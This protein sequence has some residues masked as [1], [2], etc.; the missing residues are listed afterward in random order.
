MDSLIEAALQHPTGDAVAIAGSTPNHSLQHEEVTGVEIDA[1]K[2]AYEWGPELQEA[3]IF[4]EPQKHPERF[5]EAF[6]A[7]FA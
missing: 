1:A 3:T 7:L 4:H 5:M 6:R 2:I